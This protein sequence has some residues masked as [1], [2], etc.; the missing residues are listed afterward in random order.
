VYFFISFV[1]DKV[2]VGFAESSVMQSL[3]VPVCHLSR[4]WYQLNTIIGY[5]NLFTYSYSDTAV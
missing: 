2:T 5:C 1:G 3:W 4:K